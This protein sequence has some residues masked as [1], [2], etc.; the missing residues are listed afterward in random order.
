MVIMPYFFFAEMLSPV[1]EVLGYLA[2]IGAF[3]FGIISLK[4][5]LLFLFLAIFYGVF[6]SVASIFLE[7]MT[8]K[9]YPSGNISS[10][11]FF[12]VSW[13]ISDIAR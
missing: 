3:I 5:F 2:M 12:S 9:R 8:Y 6:L 7:E 4:F 11:S 10:P 13:R 1:V